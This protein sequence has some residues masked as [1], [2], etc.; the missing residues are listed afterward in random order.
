MRWHP[1]KTHKRIVVVCDTDGIEDF[2]FNGLPTIGVGNVVPGLSSYVVDSMDGMKK[3]DVVYTID[4]DINIPGIRHVP[5]TKGMDLQCAAIAIASHMSDE[6]I[7]VGGEFEGSPGVI[8]ANPDH[9]GCHPAAYGIEVPDHRYS[10]VV[11][12]VTQGWHSVSRFCEGRRVFIIGGG[13]SLNDLN[14]DLLKD[15]YVIGVNDAYKLD[16][17]DCVYFG[18][19]QWGKHHFDALL[20]YDRQIWTT[21]DVNHPNIKRV[22]PCGRRFSVDN[23]QISVNNNSG[24]GAVNLATLAGASE[25]ILLGFDMQR[26]G[27]E[28][29]WHDDNLRRVDPFMYNAYIKVSAQLVKDVS[30]AHPGLQI[31]NANPES[32][33]QAFIKKHPNDIIEGLMK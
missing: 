20:G 19:W 16:V 15:E 21:A 5:F 29:N 22:M 25:I 27:H 28:T 33:L 14:L 31:I 1:Q 32:K 11:S 9:C 24:F 23:S 12:A 3:S 30:R 4:P 10:F 17:C 7:V 8:N 6:V 26:R 13:P 18:D 2:K